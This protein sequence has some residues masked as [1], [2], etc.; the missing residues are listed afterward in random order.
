MKDETP[1]RQPPQVNR[2]DELV[3]YWARET[4]DAVACVV[5]DERTTYAELRE[6]IDRLAGA[7]VAFGIKKGDRIATLGPP[8]RDFL[9]SF[10]ASASIGAIWIGLNPRYQLNELLYVL[11]DSE[12]RLLLT[13]TRLGDRDYGPEIRAFQDKARSIEQVIALD[14]PIP[15]T[16]GLDAFCALAEHGDGAALASAD[17][18]VLDVDPCLII[19]TSGSTGRPKGALLHHR[20]VTRFALRQNEIWPTDPLVTL[21]YF[22]I[23]HAGCVTDLTVPTLAAGGTSVFME[24]FDPARSMELMVKERVT[25]WGSVPSVFQ[26]QLALESFNDYD[27][28]AVQIVVWEGAAAPEPMIRRLL[29]LHARLTT[30][31]GM[32]ETMASTAM[33]PTS[34]LEALAN[35]VGPAFPGVEI[36]LIQADGTD[37]PNGLPGEIWV[38]SDYNFAG[39]WRQPEATAEALTPDGFFKTGDLAIRRPDGAYKI[40]GRIKEMYKSGG[41]NVYPREIETVIEDHPAV[42]AAAVVAA[43]DPVWQEVG[44]AYVAPSGALD[45]ADLERHCRAHLANYKVPKRFVIEPNLPLLP[46]G[47]IDKVTLKARAARGE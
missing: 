35:S 19:Y 6:E 7:F 44:V 32:T 9:V 29:Q 40:V 21:N 43:P 11:G 41:Y 36:R 42:V 10:L 27:L 26:M 45:T 5:D 15:G 16:L 37:A 12:P 47:K 39:Y 46:V 4:P 33:A 14:A 31:Y 34:D 1:M 18:A 20:G 30:N 24:E 28:S 3:S 23:N 13:R 25:M 38:R 22:P 17:A 2:I 8:N